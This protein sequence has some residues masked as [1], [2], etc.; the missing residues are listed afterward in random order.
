MLPSKICNSSH[1][2]NLNCEE[3]EQ[4][5]EHK[6]EQEHDVQPNKFR[7]QRLI[8]T[9]NYNQM[10]NDDLKYFQANNQYMPY[11]YPWFYS[12]WQMSNPINFTAYSQA[13]NQI[14]THQ[15][16][17]INFYQNRQKR[18]NFNEYQ[19]GKAIVNNFAQNVKSITTTTKS[20]C[21]TKK[22]TI[23]KKNGN[24]NENVNENV[25][26]LDCSQSNNGSQVRINLDRNTHCQQKKSFN[27]LYTPNSFQKTNN[28]ITQKENNTQVN[29]FL[30]NNT[31]KT[32]EKNLVK[33]KKDLNKKP[34]K[35]KKYR[36]V[37]KKQN[38][39]RNNKINN[40]KIDTNN[41]NN[42]AIL[43]LHNEHFTKKGNKTSMFQRKQQTNFMVNG[44]ENEKEKNGKEEK[45]KKK[46]KEKEKNNKNENVS[47]LE[48]KNN[49]NKKKNQINNREQYCKDFQGKQIR[50]FYMR[51]M[52]PNC[53]V[54]RENP[55]I[56]MVV[57]LYLRE[58]VRNN[59]KTGKMKTSSK[60]HLKKDLDNDIK[61]GY[62]SKELAKWLFN[63]E[64]I[65]K[66]FYKTPSN[67]KRKPNQN[68][69]YPFKKK[70]KT[71]NKTNRKII[72]INSKKK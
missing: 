13:R 14:Q 3:Q 46:E 61:R 1:S 37:N 36:I 38:T 44:N 58:K 12:L 57:Y 65:V 17:H 60:Y 63:Y 70:T 9:P 29:N 6:Q 33:R 28:L 41:N 10:N 67:R 52:N 16:P 32:Q 21:Q 49:N 25:T 19:N 66:E 68:N 7:Q 30:E 62:C 26:P 45:E 48:N 43:N 18:G 47:A 4:E 71:R 72:V 5:Q 56:G 27:K 50:E 31:F 51:G 11:A 24:E 35:T 39:T 55:S 20:M 42:Q 40:N 64:Y 15:N 59:R 2:E 23:S 8:N 69:S 22:R 53:A 54:N 34:I